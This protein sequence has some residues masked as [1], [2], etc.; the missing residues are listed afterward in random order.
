MMSNVILLEPAIKQMQYNFK[1][2]PSKAK[3]NIKKHGLSFE[4]GARVFKDPLML[5][6]FDQENSEG[7]EEHWNTLGK[8]NHSTYVV[9]C[10]T[11]LLE[12]NT[13]VAIRIISAR[14]A[15]KSEINQ[16]EEC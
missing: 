7:D 8:V 10:H 3:S 11:Y 9:V 2:D 13:S 5:T 6:L 12:S 14:I 1:W 15:T 16:Y 4:M